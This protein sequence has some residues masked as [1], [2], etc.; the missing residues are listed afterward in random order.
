MDS[1][2]EKIKLPDEVI[3]NKILIVRGEKVM[4]DSD[5]AVLYGV[6]TK[7]LNEQ[8][9]RNIKRFPKHFMFELT[10]E[11]KNELVAKCDHLQRL[12]H[13]SFLPNV[14]TQYGVL[15]AAN[16]LNSERAILMGMLIIEVFVRMHEMLSTHKEV[17][18][19][20]AKLIEKDSEQD[21]KIMLIFEYL[22]QFEETKQQQSKQENR[23][24][25]GFKRE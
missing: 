14:F 23:K 11:E 8:V 18:H 13:S 12:K 6:P 19:K 20:I 17:L 10:K 16:V 21:K 4:I 22:K 7:R 9:K 3:I 15:Q 2:N 25:I 24:L 1:F 5:L